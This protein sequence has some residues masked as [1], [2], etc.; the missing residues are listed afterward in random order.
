M[1]KYCLPLIFFASFFSYSAPSNYPARID[2]TYLSSMQ[3]IRVIN[4]VSHPLKCQ[5]RAI[6]DSVWIEVLPF[7]VTSQLFVHKQLK[8]HNISLFCKKAK[9]INRDIK[10]RFWRVDT[11][12]RSPSDHFMFFSQT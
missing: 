8:R 6:N 9:I 11:W 2:Y 7:S 3:S 4:N 5:I 10:D 12:V 1:L